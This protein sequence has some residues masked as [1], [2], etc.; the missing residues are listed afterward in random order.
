MKWCSGRDKVR[1]VKVGDRLEGGGGGGEGEDADC[2]KVCLCTD[3]CLAYSSSNL[4][5]QL[6]HD[7]PPGLSMS[8]EFACPRRS[9]GQ[10]PC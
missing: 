3:V 7:F 5:L 6:S 4:Y 8:A 1:E 10:C 9:S 2:R